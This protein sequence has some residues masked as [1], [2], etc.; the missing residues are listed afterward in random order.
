M[1]AKEGSGDASFLPF[2][3]AKFCLVYILVFDIRQDEPHAKAHI[4]K[5]IVAAKDFEKCSITRYCSSLFQIQQSY[6]MIMLREPVIR[7]LKSIREVSERKKLL[8][9]SLSVR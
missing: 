3:L 6:Q 7:R 1:C 2:G 9:Y 5:H 8:L 4:V